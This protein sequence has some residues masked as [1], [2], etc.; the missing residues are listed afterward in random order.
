VNFVLVLA[1]IYYPVSVLPG[2]IA[3]LSAA[4][5]LTHF[6]DAYRGAFGFP[7]AASAPVA[8]GLALSALYLG[9]SHWGL[10]AAVRRTRRSG[11]LLRMSE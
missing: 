7:T 9:L 10:V 1:G 4:I 6:L 11:L 2:A 3:P 8:T 5:P